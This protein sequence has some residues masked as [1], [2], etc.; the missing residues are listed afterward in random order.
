VKVLAHSL[1]CNTKLMGYSNSRRCET[2]SGLVEQSDVFCKHCGVKISVSGGQIVNTR[3]VLK[4]KLFGSLDSLKPLIV[5][6]I[7]LLAVSSMVL[8]ESHT[9]FSSSDMEYGEN[10]NL[11][12]KVGQIFQ[13]EK[14]RQRQEKHDTAD[15]VENGPK[16]I[17]LYCPQDPQVRIVDLDESER[18]RDVCLVLNIAAPDVNSR[19]VIFCNAATE[20][21]NNT[22]SSED[23]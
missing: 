22:G 21:G 2:C 3:K 11:F 8:V 18:D 10:A 12:Q 15:A 5:V 9:T 23:T 7:A 16:E 17:S 13:K 19:L 6:A 4:S 14:R 20:F 1:S